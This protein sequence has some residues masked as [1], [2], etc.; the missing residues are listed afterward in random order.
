MKTAKEKAQELYS[1][2]LH[3]I[4][5]LEGTDWWESAKQCAL[6]TVDEIVYNIDG[7]DDSVWYNNTYSFWLEVKNEIQKL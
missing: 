1:A 4:E 5:G 7:L 2:M 6:I 3:K